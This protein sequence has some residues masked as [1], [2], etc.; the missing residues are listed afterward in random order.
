MSPIAPT[1]DRPLAGTSVAIVA[2]ADDESLRGDFE[3]FEAPTGV[4]V[5]ILDL[6]KSHGFVTARR[7]RGSGLTSRLVTRTV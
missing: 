3:G 7:L 5:Q 2:P 6:E 4:D 1:P